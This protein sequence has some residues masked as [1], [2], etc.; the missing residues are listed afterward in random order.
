MLFKTF[1]AAVFGIDA[2]LVEVEV[3][4]SHSFEGTFTVVGLPDIAVKESRERIKS[5]LRNCGFDFPSQQAVTI[6][7]APADIRKEGSAFDLPM[8]LGVLGCQGT[9]FGKILN[10]YVFLGELSLDGGVRSV[11]GALSAALAARENGIRNVVVPEANA[12]EAAVVEGIQV[13][14]VKSLPPRPIV[15]TAPLRVLPWKPVT[16]GMMPASSA[17]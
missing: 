3:D 14:A 16:T 9:F 15:E 6:N 8:A 7:L 10:A 11:R 4:V 17:A 5:A 2:Y 13:F 12:R 1:S